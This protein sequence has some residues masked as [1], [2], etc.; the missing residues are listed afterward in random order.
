M[1]EHARKRHGSIVELLPPVF[2]E[3]RRQADI[4]KRRAMVEGE[5]H[6]FFLALLLNV[7]DRAMVLNLIKQRF[8]DA[9]PVDLASGWVKELIAI[10]IFG[11]HEQNVLG[12]SNFDSTHL[13]V[14]AGLLRGLPEEAIEAQTSAQLSSQMPFA[15]VVKNIKAS[16]LFRSIFSTTTSDP[17]IPT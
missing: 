3:Q 12:L 6:R 10:R 9:D 5:D 8:P 13:A 1:L 17:R 16:S 7:P 11:S 14:L 15:D 2:A 4:V